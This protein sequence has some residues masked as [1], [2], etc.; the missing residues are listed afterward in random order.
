MGYFST[1]IAKS[2]IIKFILVG[3]HIIPL[4]LNYIMIYIP[5]DYFDEDKPGGEYSTESVKVFKPIVYYS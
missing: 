1:L 2:V 4:M 5:K 3:R